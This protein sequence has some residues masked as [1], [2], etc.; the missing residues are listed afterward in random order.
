[1]TRLITMV[2][3]TGLEPLTPTLPAD[4]RQD[5]LSS[6]KCETPYAIRGFASWCT[7]AHLG[8]RRRIRANGYQDGYQDF[9]VQ[10][11]ADLTWQ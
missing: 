9:G 7:A 4:P 6:A 10:T 5:R 11:S 2:E 3:L 1:M 8:E